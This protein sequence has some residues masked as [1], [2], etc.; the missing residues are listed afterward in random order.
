MRDVHRRIADG[1][2]RARLA[3][4]VYVRRLK[5]YIGAYA[6][7]MGGLDVLT[8][9]AGVGEND[10]VVRAEA[11]AGLGVLGVASTRRATPRRPRAP[12]HLPGRR[13]GDGAGGA[14]RRGAGHRPPGPG[15]RRL[16]PRARV[17]GSGAAT[18][19]AA[20]RAGRL[21]RHGRDPHRRA[22][23]PPHRRHRAALPRRTGGAWP[24]GRSCSSRS[25]GGR[26]PGS[27]PDGTVVGGG[28][29]RRRPQ[30]RRHRARRRRL[31]V[32][33][34]RLLRLAGAPRPAVPRLAAP[35][36]VAAR[37]APARRPGHRRGDDAAHRD[38]RRP[39]PG[40]Q[41]PRVRPGRGHLVHRPRRPPGAHRPTAPASTG[42]GPTAATRARSS[43]RSTRPTASACRPP[44]TTSTSQRPTRAAARLG[45]DRPGPGDDTDLLGG[46][47][48][49]LL[50]DPGDGTLFDSLAVDGEGW[51]CVATLGS[52]PG[53]HRVLAR[54]APGRVHARSPTRSPPTSASAPTARTAYATLS[55]TGQLVAFDWPRPGGSTAFVA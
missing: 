16:S 41:R 43:P 28:R 6:A 24:T 26:S 34:R 13:P 18:E 48:G 52:P 14:H 51:V 25:P 2:G 27:Q 47:G 1:D 53:H 29:V 40:P 8:F 20:G 17:A 23:R 33:Q 19:R 49:R 45:R 9:T 32:Q 22:R 55:G 44:A 37:L 11:T 5:K 3:L 12:P 50:G 4:D 35:G 7:V 42:A 36:V 38:R 30:R 15:A 21:R 39:A 46:P 54:R 10:P 31:R